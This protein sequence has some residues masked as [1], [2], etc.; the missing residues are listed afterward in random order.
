MLKKTISFKVLLI[1]LVTTNLIANE[2]YFY[3]NIIISSD[4]IKASRTKIL[5][6]GNVL[7]KSNEFNIEGNQATFLK[8]ESTLIILGSPTNVR[9]FENGKIFNGSANRIEFINS[10][11]LSLF[12][13]VSLMSEKKIIYGDQIK[14]N[15]KEKSLSKQ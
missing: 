5:F 14:I 6:E 13:N 10:E 4:V 2:N 12:G 8:E 15:L 3:N 1:I 7:I 11:N 9:I